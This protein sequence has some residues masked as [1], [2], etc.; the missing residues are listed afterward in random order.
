MSAKYKLPILD[1][2]EISNENELLPVV[3]SILLS[4]DTFLLKN[5]ANKDILDELLKTLRT[6]DLPD[7]EQEFDANFTGCLRLEGDIL[8]EQY[9]VNT[10][11]ELQFN[12]ECT[13]LALRK[14]YTRLFKI[15]LFFAQ[16]CLKSVATDYSA[17]TLTDTKYS[18]KLTRYFHHDVTLQTLPNGEM[19]EYLTNNDYQNYFPSGI[20]TVFPVA[21]NI[22][23][24]PPTVSSDDNTWVTIDE[25]DCL[26]LHTGKL[27]AKW[28]GG[29]H[30]TSP[31]QISPEGNVVHLTLSAPLSTVID[32]TTGQT[33]ADT[34]LN[35]Q[36][37]E[38]PEVAKKL[39]PR[40]TA[41]IQLRKLVDFYKELFSVCETVLS[42]Y[43]V[44][45]STGTPPELHSILPQVTN[46]MKR[47]V[48]QDDFL[49]MVSL[50]P[51]CYILEANSRGEL[52]VR[53]P[54]NDVLAT[55]TNKSRRL[56]YVQKADTWYQKSSTQQV[57]PVDMPICK[58]SKRRGSDG[59][60]A[61]NSF[62]RVKTKQE[63]ASS[64]PSYIFNSTEKFIHPEKKHDS[65]TN[66]LER[67]R[68]RE[69][70][71]SALLSQRQRQ[72]QQFLAVKMNQ[73]FEILY[74]MPRGKPYTVTYLSSLI[75]DSLQDSNNP[76]GPSEAEEILCNLQHL[77]PDKISV[78]T[79]DG[80]LK[81]Y[82][83]DILDKEIFSS[84]IAEEVNQTQVN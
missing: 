38:F 25:P 21:K 51:Q 63:N 74:S 49:R 48:S 16:L 52:T 5:Y 30:T 32:T 64:R 84:K 4:H 47:K 58:I 50:W 2:N 77:L 35:E 65:Q 10:D 12:R 9:I 40:E 15:G 34:L 75:V 83:W 7:A 18:T 17:D 23:V 57:I 56:E 22:K 37:E 19:V 46:M 60:Y 31:L 79:V 3:K 44:S 66:L 33:L 14:L 78:Q 61:G 81:V 42:L 43:A 69:R 54:K 1:L 29:L 11:K 53:L 13:N 28:S 36:I 72:Y 27:L 59:S 76:I 26:L 71:S 55:L 82:R 6:T 41:A 62:N 45:R 70:R 68:E 73:V 67:L 20:V 39:Y 24:K 8:L 80:G